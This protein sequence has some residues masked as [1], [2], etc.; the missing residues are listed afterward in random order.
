[1]EGG[2]EGG[3]QLETWETEYQGEI[4]WQRPSPPQQK[5]VGTHKLT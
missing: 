5:L 1:M 4:A 2:K 3:Y